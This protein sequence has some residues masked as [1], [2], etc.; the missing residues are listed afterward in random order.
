MEARTV[1]DPDTAPQEEERIPAMQHLLDNPF[2]LLFLGVAIPTVL[3]ILWGVM[4]IA[5]LPVAP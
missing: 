3:Y 5:G 1:A 2:L 4:E